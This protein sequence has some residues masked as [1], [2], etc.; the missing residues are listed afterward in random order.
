VARR[1]RLG[2]IRYSYLRGLRLPGVRHSD[3]ES[4]LIH[5]RP[6]GWFLRARAMG[7]RRAGARTIS[8]KAAD[9]E[10]RSYG[11]PVFDRQAGQA[12]LSSY[13]H[14]GRGDGS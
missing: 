14:Q 8:Q 2:R 12:E 7:R 3:E 9:G 1:K 10:L 11:L 4:G 13:L 5:Q 6:V